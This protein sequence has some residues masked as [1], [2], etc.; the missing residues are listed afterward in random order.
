VLQVCQDRA[1]GKIGT[2][3]KPPKCAV[4]IVLLSRPS[5][6][7][8][9]STRLPSLLL[10][11]RSAADP[12]SVGGQSSSH[13]WTRA[14][15]SILNLFGCPCYSGTCSH[16]HSAGAYRNLT[17]LS[18]KTKQLYEQHLLQMEEGIG[19]QV[20]SGCFECHRHFELSCE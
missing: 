14:S 9:T 3:F 13:D 1:W 16:C 12:C 5:Y 8:P 7:R 6:H 17:T 18:H 15:K 10:C 11:Y 2:T 19:P 4:F 20:G